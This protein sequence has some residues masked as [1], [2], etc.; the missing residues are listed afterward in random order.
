[1]VTVN[2][3]GPCDISYNENITAGSDEE[4]VSVPNGATSTIFLVH[5]GHG[6]HT[7]RNAGPAAALEAV[8]MTTVALT[9]QGGA[10]RPPSTVPP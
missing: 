2:S 7:R 3:G 1:M 5:H 10:R 4:K 8:G 6:I 9:G